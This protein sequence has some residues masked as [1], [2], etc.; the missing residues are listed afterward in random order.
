MS[1]TQISKIQHRTGALV[2]LPQLSTG[3][4]GYATDAKKL[5]IGNDPP[6]SNTEILTE[7]S[8]LPT[9]SDVYVTPEEYGAIGDGAANDTAALQAAID[10]GNSV[11]LSSGKIYRYTSALIM[12]TNFQYF[13]GAGVL[14]PEGNIDGILIGGGVSTPGPA[15]I[16]IEVTFESALHTGTAVRI[17]NADRITIRK[18]YC[19]DVGSVLHVETCNTCVVEWLWAAARI[20][21]ITWYGYGLNSYGLGRSDVLRIV[22]ALMSVGA[23]EYGLDWD[24]NCHSLEIT[25]I[26]IVGGLGAIVRNTSGGVFPAIGRFNH[27]EVDYSNGHG[28]EIT[29]GLDYD[30]N[31]A[32]ILGPNG[33]GLRTQG[34]NNYEVRVGGGKFIGSTTGYGIRSLDGP[35]TGPG[36]VILFAG[37]TATYANFSG[38]FYGPVWNQAPRYSVD[39]DFYLTKTGNDPIMVLAPNDYVAYDRTNND[40]N[41]ILN[42]TGVA[43]FNPSYTQNFVPQVMPLYTSATIPPGILGA[44]AMVT[45][46]T[47][48]TFNA[49]YTGGGANVVPVFF[50]GS[51]WRIG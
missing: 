37:N 18:L 22:F 49:V 30:I 46:A 31:L 24:G 2:D 41:V 43:K 11:I 8:I 9:G 38:P 12:S 39:D 51:N 32:Y 28:I 16:T 29:A 3:E 45:D 27:I 34:I 47:S 21:G 35:G 50:N 1:I 42:G 15:G 48:A 44:K 19:I 14:K 23:A 4:L 20:K 33:D 10:T 13:G 17:Q 25:Y 7:Y 36:G 40:L 6:T 26:G 5:F